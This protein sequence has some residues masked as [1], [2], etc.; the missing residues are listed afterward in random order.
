MR[1][2]TYSYKSSD[3]FRHEGEMA[4]PSKDDVYA[5]LRR[6]GIRAIRVDE[7]IVPIVRRG[8]RGLRKRD[9]LL[10]IASVLTV[11]GCA[12]FFLPRLVLSSAPSAELPVER[13]PA[14]E[15]PAYVRL[16]EA[17]EDAMSAFREAFAGVDRELLSNYRLVAKSDN[18]DDFV[19]EIAKGRA[20]VEKVRADIKAVYGDHYGKIPDS[21]PV[22]QDAAQRLYG[23]MMAEADA[24]AEGLDG[25]ECALDLLQKNRGKWRVEQGMVKWDD[26]QLARTFLVVRRGSLSAS[27]RWQSNGVYSKP[28]MIRIDKKTPSFGGRDFLRR[29]LDGQP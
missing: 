11:L 7:R 1:T 8:F 28:V 9:W 13:N 5:E 6:Q 2:W 29:P 10:I 19:A 25:D 3:G 15:N 22:A 24:A 4:A 27:S 20:L 18:A 12:A 26:E 14:M 17:A 21:C 23:E 16:A